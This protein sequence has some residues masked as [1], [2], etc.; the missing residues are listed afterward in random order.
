MAIERHPMIRGFAIQV[1]SVE[2]RC[3]GG[4]NTA[5]ATAIVSNSQNTAVLGNLCSAGFASALPIYEAAGVVT[6]SGSASASCPTH[7]RCERG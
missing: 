7:G 1:N 5:S 2:S 3:L 4:D 6:I